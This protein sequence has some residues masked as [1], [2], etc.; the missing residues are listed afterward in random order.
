MSQLMLLLFYGFFVFPLWGA[1]FSQSQ[2][3][4]ADAFI[5]NQ[6]VKVAY[7][8]PQHFSKVFKLEEEFWPT[9]PSSYEWRKKSNG[10]VELYRHELAPLHTFDF[11]VYPSNST[12]DKVDFLS[13]WDGRTY[14]SFAHTRQDTF[15]SQKHRE[16]YPI[17]LSDYTYGGVQYQ[18]GHFIDFLDTLGIY[19]STP[20][21]INKAISTLDA[22]NYKPEPIGY[23][24]R[25]L[26]TYMVREI[27]QEK[28]CYSEYCF[29]SPSPNLTKN[30]TAIPEGVVF[31]GSG[32]ELQS[33]IVPWNHPIHSY[34][35][36]KKTHW[37]KKRDEL[38]D[39]SG[40]MPSPSVIST[41]DS[42]QIKDQKA[43]EI[44][45]EGL[46]MQQ[47]EMSFPEHYNLTLKAN[48]E[49]SSI[50]GKALLVSHLLKK[51][52]TSQELQAWLYRLAQQIHFL[53]QDLKIKENLLSSKDLKTLIAQLKTAPT[54]PSKQTFI[55]CFE[56]VL[57][58]QEE[59][60]IRIET[61]FREEEPYNL[62]ETKP[63]PLQTV[64]G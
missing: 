63:L 50:Q 33:Y 6:Y 44:R 39:A 28:G 41:Q 53:D 26:R 36:D 12:S 4:K 49:I 23:F 7:T 46:T 32:K 2:M 37:T 16:F 17:K 9:L 58:N 1:S 5:K 10:T 57:K 14:Q 29:Y 52:Q 62:E 11:A 18:R 64:Q 47:G 27:R 55:A 51:N 3:E 21:Q 8:A 45:I 61:L 35:A 59:G 48:Q 30:G 25:N 31:V 24:A 56:E 20:A 54:L 13:R 40:F 22:R 19:Q 34:K 42:P 38:K 15:S 60:R 43:Q